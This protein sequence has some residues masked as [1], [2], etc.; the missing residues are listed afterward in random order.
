[1]KLESNENTTKLGHETQLAWRFEPKKGKQPC[2]I[3]QIK[4]K[5]RFGVD[6]RV[7]KTRE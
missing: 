4:N 3:K 5:T 2:F 7:E 1:M 6:Y